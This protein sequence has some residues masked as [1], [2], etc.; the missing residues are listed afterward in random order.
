MITVR[1]A[2]SRD[3]RAIATVQVESWRVA[4]AGLIP[5]DV[6]DR[7]D[8]DR[9]TKHRTDRWDEMHSD[10]R[11]VELLA[12]VD[13]E[14][15]GWASFGA[16]R[17]EDRATWGE[18]LA[19]YAL[20]GFWGRGVGHALMAEVERRLSDSGFIDCSLWVLDGN[21]RAAEFYERHG[22]REDGATKADE[23]TVPGVT[24]FDRRRVKTLTP[25]D[26][27]SNR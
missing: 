16:C 12:E 24:L 27:S 26:S 25:E 9:N 18:I 15:A 13:G 1:V 5:D 19:F 7:L 4:Y 10:P 21:T 17:D 20:P 22:W 14:L 3:T 6:L 2:D 11:S 23:T 8:I